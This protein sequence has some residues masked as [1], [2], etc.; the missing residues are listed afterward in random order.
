MCLLDHAYEVP[1]AK[2]KMECQRWPENLL[3]WGRHGTQYCH[4]NGTVKLYCGA[5]VVESYRRES[6]ISKPTRQK[7]YSIFRYM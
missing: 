1:L 6:N 5:H 3:I 2:N 7:L 4:G